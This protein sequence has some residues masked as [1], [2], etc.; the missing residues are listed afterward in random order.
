MRRPYHT[1]LTDAQWGRLRD[2]VRLDGTPAAAPREVADALLYRARAWCP[3][4][5][6]PPGFPPAADL[7]PAWDGWRRDGTWDR[8]VE[9]AGDPSLPRS[10]ARG[11]WLGRVRAA[12]ARLVRKA[13]GGGGMLWPGRAVIQTVEYGQTYFTIYS[14]L[15]GWFRAGQ[16]FLDDGEYEAAVGYFSRI[17]ALDPT[18][19]PTHVGRM[20]AYTRSG[21]YAEAAADCWAALAL[22][23]ASFDLLVRLHYHLSEA[24]V[25][26]GDIERGVG[27]GIL[28]RTLQ[29]RGAFRDLDALDD[30]ADDESRHGPDEFEIV[31]ETYNDMAECAINAQTDFATAATLYRAGDEHRAK[32]VRWLESTPARTLYLSDDWVRNI[33]HMALIDFWVK[34]DR[35]GWR[36]WDR[37]LLSAPPAVTANPAYVDYY[38]RFFTVVRAERTPPGVK[39]L[40]A[41]LGP[42]VASLLTLPDGSARYFTEGMGLIQEAWEREGR[43]PLLELTTEHVEYGRD[44]LRAMGVPDGAWFVCL[45]ARSPGFH[46]EG[47]LNAHQSHRNADI[48]T[49]LPAVEEVVRRGGWVIRL[50]DSTMPAF[51]KTPGVVDYARSRLKNARTDIFLCG[52]CRFFIGVASGISHVPTTFGVPCVMTNWLSNALPVYGRRDLFVLKMLRSVADGRFVPFDSYLHPEVRVMNYSGSLISESGYEVVNNTPDE[53]K[54]VVVEMLDNLDRG[55]AAIAPVDDEDSN[56]LR[57]DALAR[58]CGLAGF[59]RISRDFV[60]RH[61]DL[62]PAAPAEPRRRSA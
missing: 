14:K 1:D 53:L 33:G 45:H 57:F 59:S 19:T 12:F 26:S 16:R 7:R 51:P 31:A 60:A 23:D 25:L 37:M 24:R 6:L 22:P 20:L 34:M 54:A 47:K 40:T 17:I 4:H 5:L 36:A 56:V 44:R 48:R 50:G 61:A 39:H 38:A 8:I 46:R 32:Y 30:W 27:H 43:G 41:T 9:V 52:G 28:A 18:N 29:R 42:R 3:W 35:L 15:P 58:R 55:P 49:Y 21:L 2:E 13:P 10:A 11:S 62:L